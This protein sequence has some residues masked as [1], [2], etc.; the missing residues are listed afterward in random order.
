ML[1]LTP[2]ASLI[3]LKYVWIFSCLIVLSCEKQ[4]QHFVCFTGDVLLDRGIRDLAK[5]KGDGYF[6][7]PISALLSPYRYRFIN[8]E[9]PLT[10]QNNPLSKPIVFR[11][12]PAM[13]SVLHASKITHASLANNHANDQRLQ[14]LR[15]TKETLNSAGILASG[16]NASCT[17]VELTGQNENIAVF[18]FLDLGI[19]NNETNNL[20]ACGA[21][22]LAA[23]I[24]EYKNNHPKAKI[25]CYIHWG[26]EYNP[27][28]AVSQEETA[29]ALIDAGADAIIGHHPHVI[30]KIDYYNDKLIL[31]S[32]GNFV[33]D[34]RLP[35]TRMGIVAGFDVKDDSLQATITPYIIDNGR[36][37]KLASEKGDNIISKLAA[38]SSGVDFIYNEAGW[39]IKQ[40]KKQKE[41]KNIT[42]EEKDDFGPRKI[43][44][45]FF[46][47]VATLQ[48]LNYSKGYRLS[49]MSSDK[50]NSD[51]LHVPYP[52]YRF[53]IGDLN[54]DGKTDILLG[55]I[56]STHFD[57]K[58]TKRLFALRIDSGQIRPLWLGSKVCQNL[59]DFKV[60]D[61]MGKT[62]IL[63]IEQSNEGTFS[64]GLYE[65]EDFGLR[66]VRY[67]NENLNYAQALNILEHEN[68]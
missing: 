39:M 64:N 65:W 30:Q 4:E 13:V 24:W 50:R 21:L 5:E 47:G 56:K 34:Q 26:I 68:P 48:K 1:L 54:H 18:S 36:P 49:I 67:I 16:A 20:C 61:A 41:A 32:L 40:K 33:F 3:E 35:E 51:E 10:L 42:L 66:L 55:V 60:I 19:S 59:V 14:G 46:N 43:I 29:K 25:I 7:E 23:K 37:L 8:L 52:V 57:P 53:E 11:G 2:Q 44:D 45:K 58:V 38:M 15:D 9:C 63:T 31:Y 27:F 17:P 6:G 62:S 22:K 28:P 12:P